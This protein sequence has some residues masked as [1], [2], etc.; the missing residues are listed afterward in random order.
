MFLFENSYQFAQGKEM[1]IRSLSHTLGSFRLGSS[2]PCGPAGSLWEERRRTA[3]PPLVERAAGCGHAA[4]LELL[5]TWLAV[6]SSLTGLEVPSEEWTGNFPSSAK[7]AALWLLQSLFKTKSEMFLGNI[8]RI[9]P[10]SYCSTALSPLPLQP[11]QANLPSPETVLVPSSYPTF[12]SDSRGRQPKGHTVPQ[13]ISM[14]SL[15]F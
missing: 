6:R 1:T 7:L 11:G 9:F 10:F 8:G 15:L 3:G 12:E 5:L 14:Y 13:S 4:S 2:D